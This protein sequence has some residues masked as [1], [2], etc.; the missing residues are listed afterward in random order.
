MHAAFARELARRGG[1]PGVKVTGTAC[2]TPCQWGPTVVVYPAGVWYG[3][4]APD[5]VPEIVAAHLDEN[6]C[7]ARLLLPPD[8]QLW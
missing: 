5:D 3:A 7:V 6:Q 8:A 4:V 1:S 2:L